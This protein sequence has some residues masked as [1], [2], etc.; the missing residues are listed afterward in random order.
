MASIFEELMKSGQKLTESVRP[1]RQKKTESV[2]IKSNKIKVESRRIFEDG[3]P[4][5]LAGLDDQFAVSPEDAEAS[6]DEVVLVIDPEVNAEDEVPEDAAEQMV[7]DAVYKCPVCGANYVCDCDHEH[8]EGIE[9]DE[10]GIPTECP[11][12]GDDSEQILIGEIAPAGESGEEDHLDPQSPEEPED[13]GEPEEEPEEDETPEDGVIEEE[14]LK[15]TVTE[16]ED[17]PLDLD[18]SIPEEEPEEVPSEGPASPAVQVNTDLVNLVLDDKRLESM[19][20]Q[21]IR[22]NYDNKAN[23]EVNRVAVRKGKFVIEYLVRD[24]AKTKKGQLVG[25]GFN[26]KSRVM[27]ISFKD[28]GVF[29]ES[30]TRT[31]AFIL[32]C[33]KLRSVV[34]P[35]SMKYNY[36]VKVNE[37]LYA[38]EGKVVPKR[39]KV[40]SKK[41]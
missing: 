22:E 24:G 30:F 18:L 40:E 6:D 25:E 8:T 12:C 11:I 29:T 3:D 7:G 4:D 2:K 37:S 35:T 28:K 14:G 10:D 13:E 41:N 17:E 5:V 23:F 16:D 38:V 26:P 27:K 33:V 39:G 19:M 21:M 32:E 31:P 36:K 15:K 20:T 9:V 1:T 34:V